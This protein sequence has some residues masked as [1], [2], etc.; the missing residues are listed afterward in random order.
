[1][2]YLWSNS[3]ANPIMLVQ[4][5]SSLIVFLFVGPVTVICR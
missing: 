2:P 3:C 5:S 1:M 4:P